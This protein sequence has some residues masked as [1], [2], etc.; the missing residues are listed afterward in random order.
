MKGTKKMFWKLDSLNTIKL[1]FHPLVLN[2]KLKGGKEEPQPNDY[3]LKSKVLD[4]IT[5]LEETAESM[6]IGNVSKAS[7]KLIMSNSKSKN[8][9]K[10]K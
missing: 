2:A 5:E 3:I 10:L 6:D 7:F 4:M 8:I 1:I 9:D